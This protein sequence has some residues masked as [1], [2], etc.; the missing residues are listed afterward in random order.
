VIID[1]AIP[2]YTPEKAPTIPEGGEPANGVAAILRGNDKLTLVQ[3]DGFTQFFNAEFA[4]ANNDLVDASFVIVRST[5]GDTFQAGLPYTSNSIDGRV[6][7]LEKIRLR[8]GLAGTPTARE[9][10]V[11]L[12]GTSDTVIDSSLGAFAN[13]QPQEVSHPGLVTYVGN[14]GQ[15]Q[16][17]EHSGWSEVHMSG[18]WKIS[19]APIDVEVI[20]QQF[21][22]SAWTDVRELAVFPITNI[23]SRLVNWSAQIVPL[24]G[25][26]D[27]RLV[28]RRT[29][30]GPDQTLFW[31]E[32]SIE[33]AC[34]PS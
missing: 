27:T 23:S 31:R 20:L 7:I 34:S 22:F 5:Q 30:A 19:G 6:R 18:S 21:I 26:I 3:Y 28:I 32:P 17:P 13:L 29:D 33:W 25:G 15:V 16:F 8:L 9:E 2:N 10:S 14:T 11:V 1:N 12:P 4:G 24:S